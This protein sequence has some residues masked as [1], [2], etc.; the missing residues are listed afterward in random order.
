MLKKRAANFE[1]REGELFKVGF[2]KPL[3]KYVT[4]EKRREVL[5]ELHAGYCASHS[6]GRFLAVR[7]MRHYFLPT[8]EL[9]AMEFV[10][11]C[12]KCQRFG[13]MIHRPATDLTAIHSPVPFAKWG[14]DILGPYTPALGQHPPQR[15]ESAQA[16]GADRHCQ[17]ARRSAEQSPEL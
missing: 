1:I 3:L 6:G 11:E 14:M 13:K 10:K 15:G 2:F 4:P 8:L 17:H 12:D 9:D 5:K 16:S 7:A